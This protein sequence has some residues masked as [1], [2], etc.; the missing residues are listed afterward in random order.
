[1]CNTARKNEIHALKCSLK[2]L[3]LRKFLEHNIKETKR[4]TKYEQKY[5]YLHV[6]KFLFKKVNFGQTWAQI[7]NKILLKEVR[8]NYLY[9][10]FN[11]NEQLKR[12]EA[13]VY[14]IKL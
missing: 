5:I 1:M 10:G 9:P 4:N 6:N 13:L 12:N 11:Q 14:F 2:L 3:W 8:K 7:E